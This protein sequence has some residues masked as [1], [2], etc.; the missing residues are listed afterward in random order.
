MRI[1]KHTWWTELTMPIFGF[2]P[3]EGEGA[4]NEGAGEGEGAQGAGEGA[5]EGQGSAST[6]TEGQGAGEDT[7]GLKSALEKERNERKTMERELK[8]LRKD[9]ETRADAEKTEIQRATDAATQNASKVEKLAAGF[10]NSAV[11]SAVLEAAR[12]AKFLDPSDALRPEVLDAI[13][14]EQDEDDPTQVTIDPSSVT[15]A[16]KAL[17]T[18]KKHYIGGEQQKQAPKSG[19]QFGGSTTGSNMTADEQALANKYPALRGRL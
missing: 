6:G 10:R 15:K 17:A 5:G 9:A 16:V 11:R 3:G 14:V 13:G 1:T 18:S 12:A 2:E 4:G 7:S 19:S 8:A